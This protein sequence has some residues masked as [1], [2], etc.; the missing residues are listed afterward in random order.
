MTEQTKLRDEK[1]RLPYL[2]CAL[3]H[4]EVFVCTAE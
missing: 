1:M 3:L 2:L 4:M